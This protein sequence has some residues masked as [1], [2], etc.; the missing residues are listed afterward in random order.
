MTSPRLQ[1]GRPQ[2]VEQEV[3]LAR[4]Q[5]SKVAFLA[6]EGEVARV[7][8]LLAH[9]LGGVDE[10]PARSG[11]GVAYAHPLARLEQLDD[12]PHHRAGRVELAALL[13]RVVGEPVDQV[14]VG[15]AQDVAPAG[16]V[17]PQVLVAE[18]QASEVVEE[19]ADDALAVG[20][21][22][23][24]RLVVPVGRG[25]HAVQPGGVGLLD[26]V[27]GDV[28]GLAQVH[29]RA[30]NGGPAGGPRDEELVLVPVGEGHA[31]VDAR[32]DGVLHLLV[33]AVG[34]PLQEEDGE[35]VVLVVGGVD[36]AAQDVGGLPQLRL[37][38]LRGERHPRSPGA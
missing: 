8:A 3:E 23:E 4:G 28:E 35:D 29:G 16:R 13:A 5:G 21:A 37:Q 10:H 24:L 20:R 17:L 25:Q 32:G 22:A 9:V 36:L 6:V 18:V 31:A 26:G 19:A 11:G 12:E 1:A 7:A 27:A 34:Q 14:L 30:G 2:P 38:L 33:E 15:V